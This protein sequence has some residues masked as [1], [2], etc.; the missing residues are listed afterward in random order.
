M[1][2]LLKLDILLQIIEPLL[3]QWNSTHLKIH[4]YIWYTAWLP[5]IVADENYHPTQL[6]PTMQLARQMGASAQKVQLMKASFYPDEVDEFHM[7]EFE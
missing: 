5:S 7:S 2:C 3:E 4:S 6:S 1:V